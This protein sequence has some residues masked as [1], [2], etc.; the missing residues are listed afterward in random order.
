MKAQQATN[1]MRNLVDQDGDMMMS[2]EEALVL[3]GKSATDILF[4]GES[5]PS[6][7]VLT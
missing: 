1:V 7:V 3:K 2:R 4:A 6:T 5:F